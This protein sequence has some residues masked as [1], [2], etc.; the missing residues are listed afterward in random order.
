MRSIVLIL[1]A[2]LVAQNWQVIGAWVAGDVGY[3]RAVHG[4]VILLSTPTCGYCRKTRQ[5]LKLRSVPFVEYDVQSSARGASL[6]QKSGAYGVPVLM[7]GDHVIHG[8][9]PSSISAVFSEQG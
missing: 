1:L 8:F 2:F 5:Y 7:I 9:R 3:D 4:D 6:Y